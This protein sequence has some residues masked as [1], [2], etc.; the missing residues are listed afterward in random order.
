MGVLGFSANKKPLSFWCFGACSFLSVAFGVFFVLLGI[1]ATHLQQR[2][3]PIYTEVVC[4]VE[5]ARL[6]KFSMKDGLKINLISTT[7]CENPNPYTVEMRSTKAEQVYMGDDRT[8]VAS[9]TEI[10]HSTLPANGE[11][12]IEAHVTIEPTA[13]TLPSLLSGFFG[14][15]TGKEIPIYIEN[16]MDMVVNI[17]FLVGDFSTKRAFNKDC[18]LNLKMHLFGRA[19]MGPLVC[20]DSF[21]NLQIPP[22]D[23]PVTG[24][25]HISAVSMAKDDIA[26]AT[27]AKNVGLGAAMGI[28]YGLGLLLIVLGSCG[29]WRL[30]RRS[31]PAASA[32]EVGGLAKQR[33]QGGADGGAHATNPISATQIGASAKNA[34]EE[35]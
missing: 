17:N 15:L 21:D 29:M 16:R 23:H 24:E 9:V 2:F 12:S 35:V 25:M 18:G 4:R 1:W 14:G 31:H 20:G 22:A 7:T 19:E 3:T 26:K 6:D 13:D 34:P 8:P 32:R 5:P 30:F 33:P 11:G 28:G 27:E 10:P